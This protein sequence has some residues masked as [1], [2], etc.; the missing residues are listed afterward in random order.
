VDIDGV[1]PAPAAHVDHFVN[2]YSAHYNTIANGTF[3]YATGWHGIR[4]TYEA[5]HNKVLDNVI[6]FVGTYDDGNGEDIG[7]A[8][9]ILR[10]SHHNLIRGN[11][12][13]RAAHNLLQVEN[14]SNNVIVENVF[15][16]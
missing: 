6:E 1:N 3:R 16:N 14:S 13:A 12:L 5:H 4:I 9:Q 10:G 11:Q 8:V 7:D 15:E 2:L